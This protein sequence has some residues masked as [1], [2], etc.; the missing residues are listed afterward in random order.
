MNRSSALR[1]RS[2]AQER[3]R[4]ADDH[5]VGREPG[6]REGDEDAAEREQRRER[7]VV[8]V[9]E[10][11]QEAREEDGDL[12]IAQIAEEPLPQRLQVAVPPAAGSGGAERERSIWIPSQVR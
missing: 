4:A 2:P 7:L 12:R 1:T 9:D 10:L 8:A 11:R 6:E 3:R 5:R